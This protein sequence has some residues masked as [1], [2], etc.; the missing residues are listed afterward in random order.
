[1][2]M[3]SV[4]LRV[5]GSLRWAAPKQRVRAATKALLSRGMAGA[6]CETHPHLCT[7]VPL[8]EQHPL[9]VTLSHWGEASWAPTI[10]PLPVP[11]VHP[12]SSS[13]PSPCLCDGTTVQMNAQVQQAG[14]LGSYGYFPGAKELFKIICIPNPEGY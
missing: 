9:R 1:M 8:G 3:C 12:D 6:G 13:C 10:S 4:K 5:S 14:S 11:V 2:Q 7:P